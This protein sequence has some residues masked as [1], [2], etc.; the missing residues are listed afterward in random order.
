[1]SS[2]PIDFIILNLERK[3]LW[4][5]GSFGEVY[6]V[7]D[8]EKYDTRF[9]VKVFHTPK[10]LALINRIGHGV[11]F[12]RETEAKIFRPENISPKIYFEKDTLSKR[13]YVME[14]DGYNS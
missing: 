1:M 10:V 2:K 14:A 7:T 9:V 3:M 12:E 8:G 11:T 4:E 6:R 5:R 13:Y